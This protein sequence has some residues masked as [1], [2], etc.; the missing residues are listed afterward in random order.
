VSYWQEEYAGKPWTEIFMI[1]RGGL[2]FYGGFFGAAIVTIFYARRKNIPLWKFADVLAPSIALGHAF[3]RIGCLMTGCC[4]G[5]Q[6]SLPW[7]IHFPPGHATHSIGQEAI[8]VH[9][10]QIYESLLNIGL[11]V[12]LAW[13][14]RRKKFDGQIFAMYLLCYAVVRSFVE[15]FR[16]DY[17]AADYFFHG[18][19]SPGQF[20]SIGVFVAGLIL[21]WILRP[22]HKAAAS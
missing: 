17:K 12:F 19:L 21:F 5:K 4:Y 7:V 13:L 15:T 10:T 2:V 11:Y 14:Y 1:Q 22:R 6:C 20:T 8:G 3:G 16:A 9:P 18:A